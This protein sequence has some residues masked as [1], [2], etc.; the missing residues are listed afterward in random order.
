MIIGLAQLSHCV[1]RVSKKA[2]EESM[3]ITSHQSSHKGIVNRWVVL[4]TSGHIKLPIPPD[5]E[6]GSDQSV[7]LAALRN[8]QTHLDYLKKFGLDSTVYYFRKTGI[9][10]RLVFELFGKCAA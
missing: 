7:R 2:D 9:R 5:V 10:D 8:L 1:K 4:G 6:A 3:K